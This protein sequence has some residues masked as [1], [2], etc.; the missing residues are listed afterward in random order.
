MG[1]AARVKLRTESGVAGWPPRGRAR[2]LCSGCRFCAACHQRRPR[3]IRQNTGQW[4]RCG[5]IGRTLAD[6]N[7]RRR[8]RGAFQRERIFTRKPEA[9][10][11]QVALVKMALAI[12]QQDSHGFAVESLENQIAI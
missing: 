12:V 3:R 9:K 11:V 4:W 8:G 10:V 1:A 2:S 5:F 6:L 7:E